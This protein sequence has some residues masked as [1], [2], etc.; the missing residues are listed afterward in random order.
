MPEKV[1]LKTPVELYENG[2][3]QKEAILYNDAIMVGGLNILFKEIKDVELTSYNGKTAIRLQTNNG[4]FFLNFGSKQGQIFRFLT[5]NLKAD[6]FAVYF[7][8]PAIRG[9]VIVSDARWEKGY[10][11]ITEN[12]IWFLSPNK[13]IRIPWDNLGSVGKE[14]K[15][16]NKKQRAVLKVTHVEKNEVITSYVLCPETTLELLDQYINQLLDRQKPREKLSEIEEQ[17]LTMVYS[18]VDSAGIESILGI[19]TEELNRYYDRLIEL[20]LAKVVKIRKEIELTPKGVNLVNDAM[21]K[22]VG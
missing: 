8:S 5:F 14:L 4:E 22:V 17:I 7:I 1:L 20:G 15:T 11:A 12:A 6:R 2:W 9:G 3:I 10:L 16:V 19:P 13:Q 18:G 21:K